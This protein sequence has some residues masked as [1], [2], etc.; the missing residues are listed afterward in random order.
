M[1]LEINKEKMLAE[2]QQASVDILEHKVPDGWVTFEEIEKQLDCGHDKARI[3]M[4]KLVASGQ[5]ERQDIP[6]YGGRLAIF[7]KAV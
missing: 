6:W 4:K 5:W 2:I 1:S 7:R 3:V